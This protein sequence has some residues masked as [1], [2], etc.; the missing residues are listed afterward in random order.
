M[1]ADFAS[2][3]PHTL[4]RIEFRTICRK[5][6]QVQHIAIFSK[7]ILQYLCMVVSSIIKYYNDS[8]SF[9]PMPKQLYEKSFERHRIELFFKSSNES[10]IV[11]IYCPK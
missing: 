11:Y 5:K 2:Y 4:Y 3:F 10:S 7:K 9:F 1:G 6:F 8:F